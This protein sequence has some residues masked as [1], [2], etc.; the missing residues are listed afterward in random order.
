[1]PKG[2]RTG[3]FGTGPMTGRAAGFCSGAGVPGFMNPS[4]GG[5]RGLGFGRGRGF[6]SRGFGGG[7]FGRRNRYFA[8]GLPAWGRP[9][10]YVSPFVRRDP[11]WE[12]QTLRSRRKPPGRRFRRSKKG[13]ASSRRR[14]R[15]GLGNLEIRPRLTRPGQPNTVFH[16][17]MCSMTKGVFTLQVTPFT[18]D[19]KLDEP[20]LRILI[21]RQIESGV[22]GI[23]PSASPGKIPP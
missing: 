6:W 10:S 20:G 9:G 17:R 14:T 3:P 7:G 2:D 5:G 4:F 22:H 18:K 23:A 11:E 15:E 12:K 21:H 16:E 13:S 19:L 1:M 8:T